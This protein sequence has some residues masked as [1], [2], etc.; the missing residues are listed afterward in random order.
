[1]RYKA[2]T[3]NERIQETIAKRVFNANDKYRPHTTMTGLRG[4][5]KTKWKVSACR[6]IA[7]AFLV[8]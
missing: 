5:D 6:R 3:E 2:K 1:M 8:I 4:V 7:A